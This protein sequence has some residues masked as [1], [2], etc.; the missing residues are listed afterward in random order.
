MVPYV[1][2][3]LP[4]AGLNWAWVGKLLFWACSQGEPHSFPEDRWVG[5]EKR[6]SGREAAI[7]YLLGTQTSCLMRSKMWDASYTW[8]LGILRGFVSSS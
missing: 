1:F 6:V 2:L 3:Q 8:G 5:R 7:S 4:L